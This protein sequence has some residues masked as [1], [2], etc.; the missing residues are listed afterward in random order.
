MYIYIYIYARVG[1]GV[2]VCD[3]LNHRFYTH[4][5]INNFC[6][7]FMACFDCDALVV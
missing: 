3:L 6:N 5:P 4:I 1:V 2:C 7:K